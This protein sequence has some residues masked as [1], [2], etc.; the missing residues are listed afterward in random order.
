MM[1]ES[2]GQLSLALAKAQGEMK[3]AVKDSTNPFFKSKYADLNSV[4]N[5]VRDPLSRNELAFMQNLHEIEGCLYLIT[6]L[7][8]KSGEYVKS[9]MPVK[10]KA[11]GKTNELQSM[12]SAISYIKRYALSAMLGVC[13][14]E[15]D[16]GN[17]STDFPAEAPKTFPKAPIIS[18]EQAHVLNELIKKCPKDYETYIHKYLKSHNIDGVSNIPTNMYETLLI[19]ANTQAKKA[20][21]GNKPPE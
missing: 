19:D 15:D 11:D 18:K 8:H 1:S 5:A 2:I 14:D 21:D 9:Q 3:P 17:S 12:G 6:I 16:D 7:S 10:F 13:C 4:I 20:K